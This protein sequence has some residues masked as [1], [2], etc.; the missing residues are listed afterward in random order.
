MS[1]SDLS[2]ME[3]LDALAAEL[4]EAGHLARVAAA[5]HERPEPAFAVRLRAEL[6]RE[7]PVAPVALDIAPGDG[8]KEAGFVADMPLPPDR[9]LDLPDRFVERRRGNR[10]FAGPD[11]RAWIV[12]ADSGTLEP[13]SFDPDEADPA[14][15]GKRWALTQDQAGRRS[16]ATGSPEAPAQL[17]QEGGEAGRVA[18]LSPSVRWHIPTRVLPSRWIATGL[19]ACIVIASLVI[20]SG[21]FLP[22]QAVAAASESVSSTLIRDGFQTPLIAG[23][24]LRQGDEIKVDASGRATLALGAGYVRMDGGSDVQLKSLDSG[25]VALDQIAGRVYH[26]VTVPAGGDYTVETATVIWRATGTAFDLDCRLTSGGGE[27]VIGLALYDGLNVTGPQIQAT[28]AEGTSATVVLAADGRP[29]GAPAVEPITAQ[30]LADEWL[31]ANAG[32]D[33]RLGLPLGRL[34]AIASPE[35]TAPP[36]EEPTATSTTTP[37]PTPTSMPAPTATPSPTAAPTEPPAVIWTPEPTR[38]PTPT[39]TPTRTPA[40]TRTSSSPVQLTL[41][42]TPQE[43]GSIV[44]DWSKYRGPHFQY[45]GIVRTD[46]SEPTLKPGDG[47]RANT[48]PADAHEY[49]D[50][51][52]DSGLGALI[53]GHTYRYRVY[54]YTEDTLGSVVPNC[55]IGTIL[56]VSNIA[57]ATAL[58]PG[59]TPRS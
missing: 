59:S 42:A 50:A 38:A 28:V 15:A 7:L 5:H 41:T 23:M 10:P 8:P 40:P 20:G 6:L 31:I 11:R 57:S 43:D 48:S 1:P 45:Y 12:E 16:G 25:H 39:P 9:P 52:L 35:V 17:D 13:I 30:M 53:P 2:E 18:A 34:S 47:P 37:A 55:Y 19:A 21:V 56:G 46:G 33:A 3:Q 29:A 14:R 44:L 27:Q 24:E 22:A 49:R 4:A 54:A 51:G 32:L 58:S 26:R 36:T